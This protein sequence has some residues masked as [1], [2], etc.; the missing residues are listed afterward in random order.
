MRPPQTKQERS[1]LLYWFI[2]LK[3][4]VLFLAWKTDIV[5][6]EFWFSRSDGRYHQ[7]TDQ[8]TTPNGLLLQ[9]DNEGFCFIGLSLPEAVWSDVRGQSSLTGSLKVS[10]TMKG[11]YCVLCLPLVSAD[12]IVVRLTHL[13]CEF[14]KFLKFWNFTHFRKR[15]Q[16]HKEWKRLV[17]WCFGMTRNN[18][19]YNCRNN[20]G[21]FAAFHFQT[22]EH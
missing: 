16:L 20:W 3:G 4:D 21:T 12:C 14:R 18:I 17:K 8:H 11:V 22:E 5:A 10:S 7:H 15:K 9:Q 13:V 2:V 19:I 6:E 1:S